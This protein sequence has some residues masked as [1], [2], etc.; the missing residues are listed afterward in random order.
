M[1]E[2]T[3]DLQKKIVINFKKQYNTLKSY[4]TIYYNNNT[5][6]YDK[7][8][9]KLIED[10]KFTVQY[11]WINNNNYY[12]DLKENIEDNLGIYPNNTDLQKLKDDAIILYAN[13]KQAQILFSN[14][15]DRRQQ[16]EGQP[17][18]HPSYGGKSKKSKKNKFRKSKSKKNK[19]RKNKSKK[20]KFRKFMGGG[21]IYDIPF[22]EDIK[23]LIPKIQEIIRLNKINVTEDEIKCITDCK[24][25]YLRVLNDMKV[26][27][28]K[29]VPHEINNPD[30]KTQTENP[31]IPNPI[32]FRKTTISEQDLNACIQRCKDEYE[33]PYPTQAFEKNII[34]QIINEF[35]INYTKN[36]NDTNNKNYV[37]LDYI[38]QDI[39]NLL[40]KVVEW[41]YTHSDLE[42]EKFFILFFNYCK[43][44]YIYRNNPND[45]TKLAFENLKILIPQFKKM[46]FTFINPKAREQ[47]KQQKEQEII[48]EAENKVR[49]KERAL[50][51]IKIQQQKEARQKIQEE[52]IQKQEEEI[53]AEATN[54]DIIKQ[55]QE[56]INTT[57]QNFKNTIEQQQKEMDVLTITLTDNEKALSILIA[58]SDSEDKNT[59]IS[60]IIDII[61]KLLNDKN[62]INFL[63]KIINTINIYIEYIREININKFLL[64]FLISK[65]NSTKY[66]SYSNYNE[67]I[68]NEYI[69][70]KFNTV[71]YS[72]ENETEKPIFINYITDKIQL[73]PKSIQKEIMTNILMVIQ[74]TRDQNDDTRIGGIF[75]SSQKPFSNILPNFFI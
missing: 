40:P 73:L 50:I 13:F 55:K 56:L 49:I 8:S 5:P 3:D 51:E 37:N 2:T 35:I 34:I 27:N 16:L 18:Q 61:L 41:F 28:D 7:D 57:I 12:K 20:N 38:P 74:G 6:H 15:Y 23:L 19:F 1:N 65:L 63:H 48:A 75:F 30:E 46:G 25:G 68:Y 66:D 43:N 32:K 47:E 42:I 58:E 11:D 14:E 24:V 64:K 22:F 29:T 17:I 60:E 71:Y 39:L 45:K 9:I 52:E 54:S 26:F 59:R 69:Q 10:S 70:E 44:M 67:Y 33:D 31:V 36:K 62:K 72:D 4:L 21:P 53:I